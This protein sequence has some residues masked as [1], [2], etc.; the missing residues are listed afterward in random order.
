MK[1]QWDDEPT[2]EYPSLHRSRVLVAE[3][4]PEL[5]ELVASRLRSEGC[6]VISVGSGDEAL[7]LISQHD[8]T[9]ALDLAILDVRMPGMSGL[10]VVYL[11][12]M[13]ELSTPL[14]LL[15]AF[16][17]PELI[18]ECDRLRV[19]VLQKPFPLH[20]IGSVARTAMQGATW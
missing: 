16:P 11:V 8:A 13:W 2:Q 17:E 1:S 3:D 9:S 10:E 19:P 4:D 18:E 7:D 6:E 20:R 15:T 12:R 5:R 14:L